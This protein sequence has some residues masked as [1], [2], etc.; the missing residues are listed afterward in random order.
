VLDTIGVSQNIIAASGEVLADS[1]DLY[2]LWACDGAETGEA[3]R[4]AEAAG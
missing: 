1:L 4:V 2:L 3:A